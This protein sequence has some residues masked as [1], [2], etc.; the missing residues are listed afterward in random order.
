MAH[1]DYTGSAKALLAQ[2]FQEEQALAAKQM[3]LVSQVVEENRSNVVDLRTHEDHEAWDKQ[4]EGPNG[5]TLVG[6]DDPQ[7]TPVKFRAS[8][9]VEQITIGKDRVYNLE[10]G[11][12][13][14][15]PRWVVGHLDE[16]QLVW[17]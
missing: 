9:T 3:S 5:E 17:H 2:K 15:A 14:I 12:T 7:L 13:Y 10:Q 4:Y 11:Q 16:K 6:A 1:G 8:D